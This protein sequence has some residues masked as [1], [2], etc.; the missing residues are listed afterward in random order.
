MQAGWQ[1]VVDLSFRAAEPHADVRWTGTS[2]DVGIVWAREAPGI[3]MSL[4]AAA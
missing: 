3:E 1:P 2:A 4:E